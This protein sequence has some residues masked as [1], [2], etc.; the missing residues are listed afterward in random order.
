LLRIIAGLIHADEGDVQLNAQSVLGLKPNQRNIAMVFQNYALYPH[1]TVRD[2]IATP[3]V[4]SRMGFWARQPLLHRFWPG[5]HSIKQEI[6]KFVMSTA[7]G[8]QIEALLDRKPGQLSGGQKQRVALARAMVRSPSVFLMDEPLSN[9]D[10]KLR[11]QVRDELSDLHL[12]LKATFLYV[13]HDQTEALT[14]SDRVAVMDAGQVLQYD[15]PQNLYQKPNNLA[16][17]RFIGNPQINCWEMKVDGLGRLNQGQWLVQGAMPLSA[18]STVTLGLRPEHI[19]VSDN[20]SLF[21][22]DVDVRVKVRVLRVENHGPD[23]VF[24]A[25]PDVSKSVPLTVRASNR[26]LAKVAVGDTLWIGWALQDCLIFDASGQRLNISL[27][28]GSPG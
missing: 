19:Q 25:E 5:N 4:M 12:R 28:P 18:H 3:L 23:W 6:E 22:S 16:V 10:A 9:L 8:L 2:N 11:V 21:S 1:M 7:K 15:S 14:L 13:T 24:W 26:A 17:A 27:M 20:P